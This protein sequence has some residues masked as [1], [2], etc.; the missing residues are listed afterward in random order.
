MISVS[1][2]TKRFGAVTV[3]DNVSFAVGDCGSCVISGAS[4][5][6]KTTLLRL[7]AGLDL[8]DEGEI[9]LGGLPVST[10]GGAVAPHLRHI[11]F[12]FQSPALWPHMTVA[13]HVSFGLTG[14]NKRETGRRVRRVLA[15]A[16]LTHLAGRYPSRLSGGEKR[17]V[18]LARA[19]AARP[20]HLLMDEPL[21]NLDPELKERLLRFILKT[22]RQ[23]GACLVYVTHDEAEAQAVAQQ[24]LVLRAGRVVHAV[25]PVEPNHES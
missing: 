7:I 18:A 13:E 8:P 17:R 12:V 14:L 15:D 16:D 22:H 10:P 3:L 20:R 4:G 11:G 23:T 6:G 1:N 5:S 19:V 21:A 9:S 2:I 25:P 24:H